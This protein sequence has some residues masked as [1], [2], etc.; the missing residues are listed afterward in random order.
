M[1]NINIIAYSQEYDNLSITEFE[2]AYY[3]SRLCYS[4]RH[5]ILAGITSMEDFEETLGRAIK[6]CSYAG[7]NIA[8]HFKQVY[9]FD[10]ETGSLRSDWLMS[11]RGFKLVLMQYPR[12]NEQIARWLWEFADL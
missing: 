10:P 7:I 11:K 9:V 3:H 2:E 4:G 8:H 12:L 6:I 1:E 5:L